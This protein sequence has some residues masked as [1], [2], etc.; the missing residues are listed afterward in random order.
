M[1]VLVVF[2]SLA[3]FCIYVWI[4]LPRKLPLAANFLLFMA[5]EAV[6]TNKLTIIG[7]N[8]RLFRINTWS[9][10]HFL[11][12][13]LHNDFTI[14]FVLLTFA[15]VYLHTNKA[16]VRWAISVYTFGMQCFLGAALRWNHVLI[17]HGWGTTRES[18]MILSVMTYTLL[19]GKLFQ[20]MALREGWLR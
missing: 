6:L 2:L 19:M 16:G 4:K 10:P 17:D 3:W 1:S 14:T 5:I 13:I 8:L 7:F 9:I 18:M 12:M 15:N 11:S 20:R